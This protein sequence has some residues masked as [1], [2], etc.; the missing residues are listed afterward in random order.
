MTVSSQP[1][2]EPQAALPGDAELRRPVVAMLADRAYLAVALL[3]ALASVGIVG[4]LLYATWTHTDPVWKAFGVWGFLSGREWVPVPAVG[5]PV[6][7]ALPFIYGTLV[8]SAIAMAIAVPI[9][10]GIALATT[11]IL[12]RRLRGPVAGT[13]NLLAAVP[14]VVFGFWGIVVLVPKARPVLEWIAEHNLRFLLI[15]A[16]IALVAAVF[17]RGL[18]RLVPVTLAA[19]ALAVVVLT[20]WDIPGLPHPEAPFALLSGPVLSGSYALSGLVLAVMALPVITAVARE[21]IATVPRDQIEAAYALGATR[22]EMIRHSV[23][24]WARSGIVGASALGLGRALGET[25][26]LAMVAGNVQNIGGSLLGPTSTAAGVIALQWGESSDLQMAALTALGL[27]I[28]AITFL[29]NLF[30]RMLVRRG[31]SGPGPVERLRSRFRTADEGT[32]ADAS[33]A[34]ERLRREGMDGAPVVPIARRL[35]SVASEGLV[36]VL[37]ALGAVPLLLLL[38][39]MLRSGLGV[40]SGDFIT[41]P[42]PVDPN[43]VRGYGIRDAMI[44]TFV[45]SGIATAVA[46]PLGILTAVFMSEARSR[47][48]RWKR[49]GD[50]IGM[51]VDVLLG[52][53]S[54]MAGVTLY[55]TLV[56]AM[57][58]FSA[59]AGGFALA[60][61]M[62]PIVVRSS[63]EVMRLVSPGQKEAAQAL[64]AP[65]WRTMWSVVL[66]AA[67]PGIATGVLLAIARASGETAPLLFTSLGSQV[68]FQGILEPIASMAQFI[69]GF[70]IQVRTDQSIEFA[71]GA[72]LVLV[73]YILILTLAANLI[74]R[75]AGARRSSQ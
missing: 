12:P 17:V 1:A 75:I 23:L 39:E 64:G 33:G 48:G 41:Q 4:Y 2:S 28:F 57:G 43:D 49:L 30:A 55:L 54:I 65:R 14:S 29:V 52:M 18:A 38:F 10:I 31:A 74:T 56:L 62:F 11:L 44:G 46:A 19:F 68:G 72:T 26:A 66:P 25:I 42:Q 59:L 16:L 7:G 45:M 70:T 8:T 58:H 61:V 35:G 63:D 21:V 20:R 69:Y 34:I 13:I 36:L 60:V 15:T 40:M 71:W 9:A 27:I 47:S 51:F 32:A 67:A 50:G 6:F 37:V 73:T 53:P 3:A 22:W 5:D 24:P